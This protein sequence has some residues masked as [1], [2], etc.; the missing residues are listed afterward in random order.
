MGFWRSKG[1]MAE[2]G[3]LRNKVNRN[4]TKTIG[5]QVVLG[6][7]C[8]QHNSEILCIAKLLFPGEAAA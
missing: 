1:S 6:V 7:L 8:E 2:G 3:T 4:P 5:N